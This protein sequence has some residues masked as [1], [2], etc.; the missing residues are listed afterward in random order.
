[1]GPRPR[2][3]TKHSHLGIPVSRE[4]RDRVIRLAAERQTTITA[5]GREAFEQYLEREVGPVAD[6]GTERPTGGR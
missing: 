6:T 4:L 1:M 3:D 5:L 2:T